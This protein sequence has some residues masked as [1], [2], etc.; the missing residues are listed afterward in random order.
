[1]PQGQ[2]KR[3]PGQPKKVERVAVLIEQELGDGWE[4]RMTV[5]EGL[6][7]VRDAAPDDLDV[8]KSTFNSAR[9]LIA[10]RN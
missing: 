9:K 8:K 5:K 10:D 4:D 3:G 7:K 2:I 1:M 6:H